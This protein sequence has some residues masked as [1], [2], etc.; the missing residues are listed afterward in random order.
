[1]TVCSDEL[2]A[3]ESLDNKKFCEE[4][5]DWVMQESG[6]L[7]TRNIHHQKQGTTPSGENPE[8]YYIEDKIEYFV[9]ID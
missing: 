4:T 5:F 2:L 9:S 6:V 8:N 1:M 7:R 3:T